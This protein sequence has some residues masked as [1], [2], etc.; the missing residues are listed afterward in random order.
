M[1]T[2]PFSRPMA[3][4]LDKDEEALAA[5]LARAGLSAAAGRVFAALGRGGGHA[6]TDLAAAT[7]L[8][9]QEAGDAANDLVHRL[10]ARVEKVP[11]GG[12][13][14]NRYQLDAGGLATLIAA[15]RASIQQEL[16]ALDELEAR[17]S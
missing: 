14:T 6:A 10:L 8:T 11:S 17:F 3:K 9:R 4:P 1:M 7:G 5:L 15:R 12:R 13:P 2:A 16:A